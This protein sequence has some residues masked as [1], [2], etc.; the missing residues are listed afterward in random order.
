MRHVLLPLLAVTL[1][2]CGQEAEPPGDA[3]AAAPDAA[4][5][6]P[7]EA[8]LAPQRLI[9]E[10][11]GYEGE[12]ESLALLN[13]RDAR[14]DAVITGLERP[15]A[16]EFTGPGEALITETGG[17][18]LRAD[19]ATGEVT[20]IRGLPEIEATFDQQGLLDLVLHPG[21]ENNRRIYFSHVRADPEA[22]KLSALV[23]SAAVLE[24]DA[25]ADVTPIL[26][27]EPFGWAPA[28]YGGAL[29]FDEAGFLYVTVGDRS[30][31]NHAQRGDRLE[32]KVLRLHDDGRAPD[33][34]PFDGQPG[35][36]SRVYAL[37]LRNPQGL[38]FDPDTGHL[39][40]SEHGPMGGDEVNRI[41]AG[42]NYGWPELTYGRNYTG[43]AIGSG[44][45]ADGMIQ[46]LW[47]YL[48]S[49]A[50]SP[51]AVYR[52]DLFP[53][54]DGHLL[55]GA[56]R[57][58]HVS[59]LALDGDVVR[60]EQAMLIEIDDRIRDIRV[61]PDGSIWVLAQQ[62]VLYRLSREP[63]EPAPRAPDDTSW[64]YPLVCSGCHDSGAY[65]AP[66]LSDRD[67]WTG[68]LARPRAEV[69][70]RVIEGHG[71]MPARGLCD[72]CSDEHLRAVTDEMLERANPAAD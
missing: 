53:E 27:V 60:S 66:V 68:V 25:L 8:R 47:Y 52:G 2:A 37:G 59:K 36:D 34:N 1:A 39:Y 72:L 71:A 57:G 63:T 67:A 64:V 31:L 16:F 29:A 5:T 22:P 11:V 41:E 10:V 18:L 70:R 17:R 23:V 26:V 32:G 44:T 28:N 24:G 7:A 62:G 12:L 48:P 49:L 3:S 13:V 33:D 58:Q 65:G 6:P 55:V 40:A 45:H 15:W 35:Y 56:L 61:H 46:P 51:L 50:V 9:P 4:E 54:W 19:L 20:E 38:D 43:E 21:F 69:H 30:E 14:L 42:G